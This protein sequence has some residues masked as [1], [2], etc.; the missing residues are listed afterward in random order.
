ML[1]L[2]TIIALSM[3]HLVTST[4]AP[5]V[6]PFPGPKV[7]IPGLGRVEG[8][9]SNGVSVFASLPFAQPPVGDLHF[10]APQP[11]KPWNGTLNA[12]RASPICPQLKIVGDVHLGEE[13][14][15]SV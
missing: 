8:T 13:G 14:E 10:R 11:V 1:S 12:K 2:V 7:A 3:A 15:K 6:W 4:K 5:A 9:R